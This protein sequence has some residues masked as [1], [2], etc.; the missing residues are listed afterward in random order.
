MQNNKNTSDS[1]SIQ[2][3]P[4]HMKK[5]E[6]ELTK[7][8]PL[9]DAVAELRDARIPLSSEN[10]NLKRLSEGKPRFIILNKAD[11]ADE[12]SSNKW[13]VEFKKQGLPVILTDCT[14]GRGLKN[15]PSAVKSLL[16]EKINRDRSR[17]IVGRPLRVM[18]VGI[19]N[20]GKSTLIN[21]LSKT[22]K[23]EA[24]DRPGVTRQRQ[25]I[26]ISADCELLDMPGILVPKFEDKYAAEKLAYTGAIT[27]RI[28]DT[29]TLAAHLAENLRE[30]YPNALKTRYSAD[31]SPDDDGFSILRKIAKKRGF[32][33][34][35]GE[36]DTERAALVLLDE[37]R[38]GKLGRI[39]L[40]L[41]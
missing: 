7:S 2:W 23:A 28:V 18:I 25:W 3:F 38:G 39:T 34:S 26:R 32:L 8:L 5:A 30:I 33:I 37:F 21:R 20:T 12:A 41:P 31:F 17:G 9:V 24:Q 10:P 36:T 27:D 14:S 11:L 22:A 19:P 15:F 1:L 6:R 13:V 4:G 35:G 16:S 40:E 29:E